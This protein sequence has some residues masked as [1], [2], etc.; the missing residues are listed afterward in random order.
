MDVTAVTTIRKAGAALGMT[1]RLRET[2]D[3]YLRY[4]RIEGSTDATVKFYAKEL[5]LFLGDLDPDDCQALAELTTTHVLEH[6]ASMRQRDLKPR[7][8]RTRWQAITT[9]LN[10]C[11]EWG[12]IEV[13]SPASADQSPQGPQ[14]SRKPFVDRRAIRCPVGSL[15]H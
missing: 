15:P 7:S 6:L 8:I 13:S 2:L 12:L 11:V 10:W 1:G 3:S 9:W 14:R 5:R 4:H